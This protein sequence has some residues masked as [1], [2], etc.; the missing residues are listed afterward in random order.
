MVSAILVG[1]SFYSPKY[2]PEAFFQSGSQASKL[3]VL[4]Q[5]ELLVF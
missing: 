5:V 1:N 2:V 3:L 4:S